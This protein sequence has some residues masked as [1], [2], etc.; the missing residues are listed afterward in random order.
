[1]SI[2]SR[3]KSCHKAQTR[4]PIALKFG[5]QKAHLGTK[6]GYKYLQS[7]CDYS[8][9]VTPIMLPCSQG[10][11]KDHENTVKMLQYVIITWLRITNRMSLLPDKLFRGI[12]WKLM[13]DGLIWL[14]SALEQFIVWKASTYSKCEIKIL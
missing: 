13:L 14:F 9:K 5:T 12:N 6:L 8:R 1:M 3:C 11:P 2:Y 4:N 7:F 10:K